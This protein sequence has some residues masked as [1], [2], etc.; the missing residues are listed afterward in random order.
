MTDNELSVLKKSTLFLRFSDEEIQNALKIFSARTRHFEKGEE[1]FCEG[2]NT[3]SLGLVLFGTVRVQQTDWWGN[4]NILHEIKPGEIFAEAF[5]TVDNAVL[6]NDVISCEPSDVLF[7][8]VSWVLQFDTDCIH[9]GKCGR[10]SADEKEAWCAPLRI[11]L[12]QNLYRLSSERNRS[13]TKKVQYLS[14][15]TTRAKLLAYLS[16]QGRKSRADNFDIPFDR[17]ELANYLSVERTA[18]SAELGKMQKDGL[19][20]FKKNHFTLNK[21]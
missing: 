20:T 3:D 18:M 1:I 13:L 4:L 6:S 5:A 9:C 8:D 12:I 21:L 10:E 7:L 15:R 16:E 2:K 19:I 17:Q 14:C 11:K